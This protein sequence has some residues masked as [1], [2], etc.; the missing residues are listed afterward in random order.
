MNL[1]KTWKGT[2]SLIVIVVV[3]GATF[4]LSQDFLTGRVISIDE[5]IT[6]SINL[7]PN[8]A[9]IFIAEEKGYFE[10]QGL[11]MDYKGFPTG[12]LALDALIGGGSDIATTADVPIALAGLANQDISVIATIEFSA[13]NIQVVARRNSDISTERDLIGKNIATTRGGGP[14]FFTHKFLERHGIGI[15]DV[16]LVFLNPSDMVT[17]LVKGDIDAFIVFEPFPFLAREE[18][19]SDNLKIFSPSDLYGETWNIVVMKDFEKENPEVIKKFIKSLL[20]A[21]TFLQENP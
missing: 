13:D 3:V 4:M 10:E 17:V 9:L 8:S 6:L 18:I 15:S 19:G 12:K 16:N 5:H 7:V 20:K 14:L 11:I 1:L 2:L 21:E